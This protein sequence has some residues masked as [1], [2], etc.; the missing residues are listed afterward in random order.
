MAT[1]DLTSIPNT[2][3]LEI[4][5]LR[6]GFYATDLVAAALVYLDFFSWLAAR[7]ADLQTIC[8]ELEITPR[9]TDVMLTLF[10]FPSFLPST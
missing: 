8:R 6:D 9:P 5:R 10:L 3:P 7:P 2:D 1:H 4:Y